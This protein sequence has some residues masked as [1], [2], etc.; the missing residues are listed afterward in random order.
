MSDRDEE[1][2]GEEVVPNVGEE[3]TKPGQKE[4]VAGS[5]EHEALLK[6]NPNASS[7]APEVNVVLPP[8]PEP[9][10]QPET[11]EERALREEEEERRRQEE[12]GA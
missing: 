4:I 6:A 10:P 1:K 12:E 3:E 5:P 11:D 9:E 8:E 2:S 7:Y